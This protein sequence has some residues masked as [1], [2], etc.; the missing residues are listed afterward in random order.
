MREV[1]RKQRRVSLEEIKEGDVRTGTVTSVADFG[2]FVDLGGLDGL[3]HVSELS[4]SKIAN[5]NELVTSR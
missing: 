4:W 3:I 5:P 1:R 2:V